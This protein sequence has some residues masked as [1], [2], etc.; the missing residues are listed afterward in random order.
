MTNKNDKLKKCLEKNVSRIKKTAAKREDKHLMPDFD[1][2]RLS[3]MLVGMNTEF[4]EVLHEVDKISEFARNS[5]VF[6]NK[7][8]R[9][10]VIAIKFGEIFMI[11]VG[12]VFW[13][14]I[15]ALEFL[16]LTSP[17]AVIEASLEDDKVYYPEEYM[18]LR[19]KTLD[20]TKKYLFQSHEL[21]L[22]KSDFM[23]FIAATIKVLNGLIDELNDFYKEV[24]IDK[25]FDIADAIELVADKLEKRY[26][27]KEFDPRR[28]MD[29]TE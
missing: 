23:T 27:N 8:K 25:V 1:T 4:N 13:Y 16:E 12:D 24:H 21:E 5:E 10:E 6:D 14:I 15:N 26:D 28:S 29:R 18:E 2:F 3:Q 20:K 9:N 22:Y 7:T 19:D 17:L 11:E